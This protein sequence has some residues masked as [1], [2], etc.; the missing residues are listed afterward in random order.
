MIYTEFVK[1]KQ[2]RFSVTVPLS[3]L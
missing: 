3:F 1:S 2:C